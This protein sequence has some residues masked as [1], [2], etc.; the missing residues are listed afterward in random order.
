MRL[1][2]GKSLAPD[3]FFWDALRKKGEI[4]YICYLDESGTPESGSSTDHF[5]LLG[6]A[7]HA[8]TWK[9][10]DA[11]VDAL[12]MKYGLQDQEVH[13]AWMVR[14]YPEQAHV[15][16]FDTL[17]WDARRRATLAVR[18][19]N[20]ARPR[21]NTQQKELLKNYRKTEAY[22]HLSR[23]ERIALV[24]ELADLVGSWNDV[25]LFAE[26]QAKQRTPGIDH[27]TV[28]FEQIVTR[29]NTYL[30]VTSGPSGMLVQDNNQ[31]VAN[32]LT[33][34]M[35]TYHRKGTAWTKIGK[36]IETPMFVD[37]ALTSMVQLADLCS[38][39]TRRF[40]E[41]GETDLFYRIKPRFDRKDGVLVGIRHFT[42][43]FHCHCEICKQHGRYSA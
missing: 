9:A 21:K 11:Q 24:R 10:K 35:R 34:V 2:Q 18:T 37:S 27:Y 4:M 39:A 25:R 19:M 12:K 38:Y 17:D 30:T 23:K 5:V 29:F 36:I 32:R 20:L 6:M 28:A 8:D 3:A 14:D 42:G 33:G 26:A 15:P 40:F 43:K 7:I 16:D 31:T 1:K 41:K 13:T 22:T